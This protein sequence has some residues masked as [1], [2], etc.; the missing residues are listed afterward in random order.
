M[1]AGVLAPGD[2]PAVF[3]R[4]DVAE[5]ISASWTWSAGSTIGFAAGSLA[6]PEA[7]SRSL[8]TR[9]IVEPVPASTEHAIGRE[10]GALWT[11]V[12]AGAAHKWYQGATERLRLDTDGTLRV[13]N[14]S[15]YLVLAAAGAG[16]GVIQTTTDL[17][18]IPGGILSIGT[19]VGAA[20]GLVQP[21]SNYRENLGGLSRKWLSLHAAELWVETLV[22]QSTMATIGG[23]ILVGPTTILTRD[24]APGDGTI[25][26]KHN[27]L[28]LHVGGVEYGSKLV[29]ESGGKFEIMSVASLTAPTITA[30]GDYAY[31]VNRAVLG[32]ANYWYAGDAVFD[33]GKSTSPA[34]AFMDL[35]SVRGVNPGST[36]GPTIVGNVRYGGGGA[37]WREH[38]AIGNLKGLYG[39]STD[40]MGAAF[41]AADGVHVQIDA[42]NGIRFVGGG[43]IV[44]GQW[45]MFA[46]VAIGYSNAGQLTWTAADG[47]LRVKNNGVDKMVLLSDGT[48]YLNTGLVLGAWGAGTIGKLRSVNAG[49]WNTGY[50]FYLDADGGTGVSHALIGNSAG[51]RVQW[52]GASL[53][54][55]SDGFTL[56]ETGIALLQATGATEVSRS[57]R[58]GS[59]GYLW[60]TSAGSDP[61]FEILRGTHKIAISAQSSTNGVVE[62]MAGGSSVDRA[63]LTLRA[64]GVG[65][66]G[67]MVFSGL[68][69]GGGNYPRFVPSVDAVHDLGVAA[70]RWRGL[71]A[72]TVS[73][74][75]LLCSSSLQSAGYV[76]AAGAV[77]GGYWVQVA[78]DSCAKPVSSTWTIL[79]S[80]R[81]A[82]QDIVPVDRAAALDLVR[83]A[84]LVRFRYNGLLG[85]PAGEAGIGVVAQDI[86]PIL[87]AS[88]QRGHDGSI[89]WN[90]HELLMLNVAA[91]QHLADRLDTLERKDRP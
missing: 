20:S 67:E 65:L 7:T 56:D 47:S 6:V 17:A 74:T 43:G 40:T 13:I 88:V 50:G 11:S 15:G 25:Y 71:S 66:G 39:V 5:T 23:R 53:K 16:N 83:R 87:P 82:K 14:G 76:T 26:V 10:T 61:K 89:G 42:T 70:L 28:A 4:R 84:P 58:W 2:I 64:L 12:P 78:V 19:A 30:Q 21:L 75:T 77:P 41:G 55:I 81:A 36:A 57:L 22:A 60:D 48:M 80:D 8:G 3:P 91:V 63:T 51:R 9:L 38:W 32:T 46:N 62:L 33:T 59:G 69:F 27:S 37:D 90:A 86:E 24:V 18:I 44:Y 54:V 35:Y 31:L 52:D 72:V 45:D 49:N 29:L 85:G 68:A 34:G 1:T 79:P 73:A